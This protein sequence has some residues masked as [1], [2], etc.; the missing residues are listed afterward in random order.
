MTTLNIGGKK[1]TVSDDFLKLSPDEQSRAVDEIASKIG[2]SAKPAENVIATTADGGRIIKADDGSLSF[3]SPNY[4]T[5]DPEK[6]KKLMEGATAAETSMSSFD[7]S[8]LAQAPTGIASLSK[9]VQGVPFLGEYADEAIGMFSDKAMQGTRSVQNAM[10]RENPKSSIALGLAGGITG[11]IPMA[12]AAGPS[13]MAAAPRSMGMKIAAGSSAAALTGGAEGT[14]SGYGAG[15]DGDRMQAA[16]ERGTLGFALGAVLGGAAPLAQSGLKSVIQWAKG[17]D[18]TV[19]AKVLGIDKK[20]AAMLKSSMAADDPAQAAAAMSRA[21]NDAMI[22]DAG[23][24]TAQLLDTAM[25]SSGAAAR[26]AGNR[27]EERAAAAGKKVSSIFD[28]LLGKAETGM[29]TAATAIAKKT[30]A[31]RSAAYERAFSSPINYADDTGRAIEEVVARIPDDMLNRAVKTANDAMKID[32]RVGKQ[33]MASIADDGTVTFSKPLDVFQLNEIKKALGELKRAAVDQFGRP[34]GDGIRLGRLEGELRDAVSAAVPE[35]NVALR[36]GG[37]KIAEDQGLELGRKMLSP[38]V[39]REQV[40][41]GLKGASKDAVAATKRGLRV[42]I[43]EQMANVRSVISDPNVD[44]RQ[45]MSVV[46]G[47]SSDAAKEKVAALLGKGGAKVL[48]DALDEATAH[49]ELR[50]AV[51][52]NSATAARTAI[53]DEAKRVVGDTATDAI[54]DGRPIEA[55]RRIIRALTGGSEA[56]KSEDLKRLYTTVADVLTRDRGPDAQKAMRIVA[57]ALKGQQIKDQDAEF[58]ANLLT[59]AG[60]LG[61]YQTGT[62]LLPTPSRAQ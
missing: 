31:T 50:A 49:L 27:I 39:T 13:M 48:F 60:A 54:R 58:V 38:N 16:K 34:T 8:T 56:R 53:Q 42:F 14:I 23:K 29:K 32:G 18:T 19:I 11:A 25:Q 4:S 41:E 52:R 59:T 61:G 9:F 21:G 33:I 20:T 17:Y 5:N 15:N 51:A 10:G 45:A 62:Q 44:A 46:K 7:Q 1:I 6:I 28:S 57:G 35:Y 12:L 22:A 24:G 43:D 36:L 47:L 3:A 55:T 2:A 37:D 30:S 26:I 40:M